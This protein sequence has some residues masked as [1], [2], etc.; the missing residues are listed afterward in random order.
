MQRQ[1]IFMWQFK[2]SKDLVGVAFIDTDLYIHRAQ[3][4]KN[5][6]VIAD[7]QHS[8]QLLRYQVGR[9][10]RGRKGE[11]KGGRRKK[12]G[13]RRRGRGGGRGRGGNFIVIAD[14]Q[15][16]IQLL[17]YQVGR[18]EGGGGGGGEG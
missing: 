5:F 15:H 4:L 11:E 9:R 18:R 13:G 8:I 1:Q 12:G 10:G 2:G 6:I 3:S 14:I 17:R 16:S 7:I